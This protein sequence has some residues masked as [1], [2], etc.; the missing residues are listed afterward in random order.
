MNFLKQTILFLAALIAPAIWAVDLP[1]LFAT[2]SQLDDVATSSAVEDTF[3]FL[4]MTPKRALH[5][6]I[7]DQL[8]NALGTDSYPIVTR[9][10]NALGTALFSSVSTSAQTEVVVNKTAYT[11]YPY[12]GLK[13]MKSSSASDANAGTGAY[14]VEI[15]YY[16]FYLNGPYYHTV[17]MNGTSCVFSVP[18]SVVYVDKMEVLTVG[19]SGAN[20]GTISLHS[21]TLCS[22]ITIGSI[23]PTDNRTF[24][25]HHYVGTGKTAY[26]TGLTY[27]HNG[28]TSTN[29]GLYTL[30]QQNIPTAGVPIEQLTGAIR[31]FGQSSA[32]TKVFQSPLKVV[33]PHKMY[34]TVLPETASSMIYRASIEY[35]EQ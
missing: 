28:T 29:G 30:F 9:Q 1:P 24:W 17:T 18:S 12:T 32:F 35:Y 3:D 4:R 5:V 25:G 10:G 20:V 8:G 2:G 13:S 22:G 33:G 23:A 19:S 34:V 15:T 27:N 7:R 11:E 31:V 21:N 16:D 14:T 6:N 26:I